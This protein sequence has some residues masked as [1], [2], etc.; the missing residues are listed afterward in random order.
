MPTR[1]RS[2]SLPKR[3]PLREAIAMHAYERFL[4]RGGVDGRDVE[5]W[6]AAESDLR[7]GR[8]T[9]QQTPAGDTERHEAEPRDPR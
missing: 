6:L 9:A 8:R 7:H 4:A 5:D 3:D 2:D 1:R